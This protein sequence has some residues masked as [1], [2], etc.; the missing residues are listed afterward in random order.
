[1]S[2]GKLKKVEISDFI[3][4]FVEVCGSSQPVEVA[5]LLNISY[6]AAKNYLNGRMPDSNVLVIISERTPYSIHWLLTGQGK[7]FVESA[8][9][10]GTLQLSDQLR[11]F[12]RRECLELIEEVLSRK[13]EAAHSKVVV[14]TP[15]NIKKEK[16]MEEPVTFSGKQQ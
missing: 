6:Q 12:V 13:T 15:G 2:S 9:T 1:M 4:R 14:L 3:K 5:R 10:E 7:K 8:Q 11:E 16:V